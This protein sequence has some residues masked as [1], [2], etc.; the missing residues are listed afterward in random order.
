LK[1]RRTEFAFELEQI[2]I[3]K[4]RRGTVSGPCSDCAG[5]VVMLSPDEAASITTV[6]TRALYRLVEAGMIH[7]TETQTGLIRVCLPSLLRAIGATS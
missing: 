2:L 7:F 3:V 1:K 5:D 6:T 4:R